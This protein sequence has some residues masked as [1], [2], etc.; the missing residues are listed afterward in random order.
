[1]HDHI[2]ISMELSLFANI[3]D[4]F[5]IKI[6]FFFLIKNFDSKGD[7]APMRPQNSLS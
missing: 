2:V 3:I 4:I 1:M 7:C 6:R 5:I